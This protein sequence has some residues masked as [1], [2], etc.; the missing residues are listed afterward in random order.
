MTIPNIKNEFTEVLNEDHYVI[1][2]IKLPR[3]LEILGGGH[4]KENEDD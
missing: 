1:T 4:N 3:T 2:L